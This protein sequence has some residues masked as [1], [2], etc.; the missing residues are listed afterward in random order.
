MDWTEYFFEICKTV[1]LKSKDKSTKT[2][3]VIVGEDHEILSTGFNG[4]PR[5]V[6]E[7]PEREERPEKYIWTEHA[8]RNA[9][10]NAARKGIPLNNST[11][12]I[13]WVP[14]VDCARAMIQSGI[15]KVYIDGRDIDVERDKRWAESHKK[16][17]EILI[18]A[19]IAVYTYDGNIMLEAKMFT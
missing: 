1:A 2:G 8:E 11:L 18:E 13:Q 3:C 4:F 12:Y 6:H 15:K 9:I 14:C 19:K 16:A 17:K 10:Y 7:T 5:G